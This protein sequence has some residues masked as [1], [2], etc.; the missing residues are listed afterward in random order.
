M[1]ASDWPELLDDPGLVTDLFASAPDLSQCGL[2]YLHIDERDTAITLGFELDRLP[3][4]P[5]PEWTA[6]GLNAFEMFLSFTGVS[7]LVIDGWTFAF[8]ETVSVE[9]H[10]DGGM[11]VEI[12][13]PGESVVFHA[14]AATLVKA[15]AYLA[16][17]SQ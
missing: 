3:D 14:R 16:S 7:G 12:S 13:G 4:Q 2:F 8:K 1:S 11:R 6:K 17:R 9:R 15:R 5:L 10:P